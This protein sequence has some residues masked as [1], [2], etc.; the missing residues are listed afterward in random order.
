MRAKGHVH[1]LMGLIIWLLFISVSMSIIQIVRL[2]KQMDAGPASIAT[3]GYPDPAL[4]D[5][6]PECFEHKTIENYK[7]K[8]WGDCSDICGSYEV[9]TSFFNEIMMWTLS[10]TRRVCAF[11]YYCPHPMDECKTTSDCPQYCE[12]DNIPK[13]TITWYNETVCVKEHLV[14]YINH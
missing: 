13:P 4:I 2:Q 1:H 8:N 14:R 6:Q 7:I 11:K 10:E 12:P 9:C 5:Y 3:I